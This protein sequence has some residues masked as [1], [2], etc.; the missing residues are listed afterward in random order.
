MGDELVR[1][2]DERGVQLVIAAGNSH[3]PPMHQNL[4]QALGT[5][6]NNITTVGGVTRSGTLW[7]GTAVWDSGKG[8]S[9]TPFAPAENIHI[10]G[11]GNIIVG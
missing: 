8:G 11:P 5:D 4:P 6:E 7:R 9:I 2:C 3:A 1:W 10:P